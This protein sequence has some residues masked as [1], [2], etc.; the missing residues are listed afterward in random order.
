MLHKFLILISCIFIAL[1]VNASDIWLIYEP[2]EGMGEYTSHMRSVPEGSPPPV[3]GV[4]CKKDSIIV[5]WEPDMS[6][7]DI[8]HYRRDGEKAILD[9]PPAPKFDD[10]R[11]AQP[12]EFKKAIDSDPTLG[13]RA[14]LAAYTLAQYACDDDARKALWQKMLQDGYLMLTLD[15][16][17]A[18]IEAAAAANM[19]LVDK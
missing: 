16:Q 10:S 2:S 7:L 19:P 14:S 17:K 8:R 18:L 5:K 6:D 12:G 4:G 9:P 13:A 11:V 15:Q 3:A 1:P